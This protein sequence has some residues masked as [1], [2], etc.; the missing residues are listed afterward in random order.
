VRW[1]GS[2]REYKGIVDCATKIMKEE[3]VGGFLRVRWTSLC[4]VCLDVMMG[5]Y[6]RERERERARETERGVV[7]WKRLRS[8]R[9][10]FHL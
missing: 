2:K 1:L 9:S 3:G 8:A 5:V 4:T 10:R 7:G 6:E